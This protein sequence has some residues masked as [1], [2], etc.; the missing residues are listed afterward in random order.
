MSRPAASAATSAASRALLASWARAGRP[1]IAGGRAF[2]S[3][4]AGRCCSLFLAAG[5]G[6]AGPART[7][8]A[9]SGWSG[10]TRSFAS[11]GVD[12][13]NASPPAGGAPSTRRP[14]ADAGAPTTTPPLPPP[15]PAAAEAGEAGGVVTY[16]APL[17]STVV[18]LKVRRVEREKE[19]GV[20]RV[21]VASLSLS[22]HA[23]THAGAASP[24]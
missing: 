11:S 7:P 4:G 15:T 6:G 22:V 14:D 24:D 23:C 2:T 9:R 1:T 5:R 8:L 17:A 20:T 16:I 19:R 10:H 3:A 12:A 18:R 13:G 21:R